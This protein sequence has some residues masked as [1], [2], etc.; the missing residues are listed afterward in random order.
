[1]VKIP[2]TR[3]V[4]LCQGFPLKNRKPDYNFSI[5]V[6]KGTFTRKRGVFCV[7]ST[8]TGYMGYLI[9]HTPLCKECNWT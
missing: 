7:D 5:A 9:F 8:N 1:M 2:I 4:L 3:M 6:Y